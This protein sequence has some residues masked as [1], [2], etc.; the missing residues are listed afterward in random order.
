MKASGNQA[1]TKMGRGSLIKTLMPFYL[2]PSPSLS[3]SFSLPFFQSFCL[4]QWEEK[5]N[6]QALTVYLPHAHQDL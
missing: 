5:H 6:C 1:Q 4:S 2:L 3:P